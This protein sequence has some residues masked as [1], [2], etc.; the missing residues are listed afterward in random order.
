MK[1]LMIG[2]IAVFGLFI[3]THPVFAAADRTVTCNSVSGGG[4]SCS[5]D[6]ETSPFDATSLWYPGKTDSKTFQVFNNWD[7]TITLNVKADKPLQT[8]NL[9]TTM[10]L[11]ILDNNGTSWFTNTI[12]SFFNESNGISLGTLNGNSSMS[13]I[14]TVTMDVNA[15]NTY[16]NKTT[17]FDLPFT[18]SEQEIIENEIKTDS[19]DTD[20]NDIN[21]AIQ[22]TMTSVTPL[23]FARTVLPRFFPPT[24][25]AVAGAQTET[26]PPTQEK[27][28][29][30]EVKGATTCQTCTWWPLL[31]LQTLG[32][33]FHY[34]LTRQ[35]S[36]KT[37]WKGGILLSIF[38]Y[39]VFL[40]LNRG[41]RNGWELWLSS[42]NVWCKYFIVWVL[43][44]F[45]LLS[46]LIRPT[47]EE[48]YGV[49]PEKPENK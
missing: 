28:T 18:F 42:A 27:T 46:Y 38:I 19:N 5:L 14:F 43:L 15:D 34:L 21:T 47:H 39:A 25:P 33:L 32:L 26:P 49:T 30:E 48:E 31:I 11:T 16:Q 8:G 6:Y 3:F 2:I 36:K 1:N 41:C 9:A 45:S 23:S 22:Q 17:S 35:K 20:K 37:F 40:F 13:F 4:F 10:N 24:N 29:L 44:V 12:N 7:K